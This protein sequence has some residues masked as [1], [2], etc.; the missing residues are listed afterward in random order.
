MRLDGSATA[1]QADDEGSVPFTRATLFDDASALLAPFEDID[2]Y[3]IAT[4]DVVKM[5]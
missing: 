3:S 5:L 1:F 2:T 4:N